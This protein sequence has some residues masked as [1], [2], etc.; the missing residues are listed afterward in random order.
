[1][2]PA[3]LTVIDLALKLGLV[4]VVVGLVAFLAD[5]FKG[6]SFIMLLCGLLSVGCATTSSHSTSYP[7][8]IQGQCE[9]AYGQGRAQYVE[10]WGEP[11]KP[12]YWQV[13]A[14]PGERWGDHWA[15]HPSGVM[16]GGETSGNRTKIGVGPNMEVNQGDLAHEAFEAW[17][18]VNGKAAH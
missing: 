5:K 17:C 16:V 15:I 4:L 3:L 18:Q 6:P 10:R 1:M 12:L 11:S 8:A 9:Q 7:A 2:N 14:I 13:T